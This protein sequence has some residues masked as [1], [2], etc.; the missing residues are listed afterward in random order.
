VLTDL[1]RQVG[2]AVHAVQLSVDLQ[3][4][5]ER[6]VSARE[7][8][9]RRLGRELHDGL[10]PQLAG[11]S[12]K[13]DAA[14]A[15]LA[16]EPERAEALLLS[17]ADQAEGAV[18]DL[19]RMAYLLRPPALD[20]L[21]LVGALRAVADQQPLPIEV[22]APDPLPPLPA[23][24]E[25]AVYRIAVE[26]MRN[27]VRHAAASGCTVRLEVGDGSVRLEVTDDG[28]G[29]SPG[30]AEG[31]GLASVRERAAEL[32]GSCT[33]GPRPGGGVRLT[34]SVPCRSP[35]AVQP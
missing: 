29:L 16:T 20:T 2:A 27:A 5:R 18:A 22:S 21:G 24:V 35:L 19:R 17:L 6:L 13:V 31:V 15:L 12:M 3:H 7:E 28:R 1:A 23:A 9:R 26:A 33:V 14:R 34:A 8:E 32:G 11:L 4:S 30:A 25:V 10:G